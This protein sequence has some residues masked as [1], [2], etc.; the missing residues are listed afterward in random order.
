MSSTATTRPTRPIIWA[1]QPGPQAALISCP[2]REI[3]FGGARGGGKTDGV[4]G[5][6]A[7]RALTF[8]EHYNA[9]VFRREMPQ[10]DDLMERCEALWGQYGRFNRSTSSFKFHIGA[11]VRFRPLLRDADAAKYQGQNLTDAFVEEAGNYPDPSPILKLYGTL[12]SA[13]G[14][15]TSLV[16]TANPGGP[17]QQWIKDRYR[18]EDHPG[19]MTPI[20][21]KLPNGAETTRIFIPSKVKDNRILLDNDP[22]YVNNLYLVGSK[23]LVKAWLEGDW[24]AIEGAFFDCWENEKHLL[25]PFEIPDHWLRFR[26]MDWGSARPFSVGWWAVASEDYTAGGGM[27]IPRGSLIRYREWYG[28]SGPNKGI[29]LTVEAV[30]DGIKERSGDENITYTTADPAMFAQDGGPSMAERCANR[31]VRLRPADNARVSRQG[32]I[33]GWDMMR[34]RLIGDDLGPRLY[35]FK[36]CKDSIRTIPVLQHDPDNAED[37]DTDSED[38]AADEWRYACMSRPWTRAKPD[39]YDPIAGMQKKPTFDQIITAHEAEQNTRKRI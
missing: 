32:H 23:E 10:S 36:T 13:Q 7:I 14:L 35:C 21:E 20:V 9:V 34:Q 6:I 1:P 30:A 19:G 24:N 37:L 17:G 28:A 29:K 5:R 2:Y 33:G 11:R 12:R 22:E 27:A 16:L 4:A 25:D 38:H 18:I 31:G 26:S 8:K 15:P 39:H 3:L